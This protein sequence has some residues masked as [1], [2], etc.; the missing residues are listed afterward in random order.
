MRT[1]PG[2]ERGPQASEGWILAAIQRRGK[3]RLDN[4]L[5]WSRLVKRRTLVREMCDGGAIAVNDVAAKPSKTLRAG[6]TI[7]LA[8]WNRIVRVEVLAVPESRVSRKEAASLYR[9]VG[10]ERVGLIP[11]DPTIVGEEEFTARRGDRH[12]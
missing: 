7:V 6:D 1:E 11:P 9:V 4:F 10:E 3:V 2:R 5:K 8:F 12:G